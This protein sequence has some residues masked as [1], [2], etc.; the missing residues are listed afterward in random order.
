MHITLELCYITTINKYM[1]LIA[2]LRNKSIAVLQL[3]EHL[4]TFKS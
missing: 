2:D 4:V 3:V 1:Y